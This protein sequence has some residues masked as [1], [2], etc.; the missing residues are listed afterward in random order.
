MA[1]LKCKCPECDLTFDAPA[2]ATGSV[3]CPICDT[4]APLLGGLAPRSVAE[5]GAVVGAIP[6]RTAPPVSQSSTR[7]AN[8]AAAAIMAP[9]GTA[10]A[11]HA[12]PTS[13]ALTTAPNIVPAPIALAEPEPAPANARR[14]GAMIFLGALA[15]CLLAGLVGAIF[16]V[17]AVW[18]STDSNLAGKGSKSSSTSSG[19]SYDPGN[20]GGGGKGSGDSSGSPVNHKPALPQELQDKV[21]AAVLKGRE[22][23]YTQV[24]SGSIRQL[25]SERPG[26]ALA[27]AALTLLECGVSADDPAIRNAAK[28]IRELN[29]NSNSTYGMALAILFLDRLGEAADEGLIQTLAMRLIA[30][31]LPSGMWT[32]DGRVTLTPDDEKRFYDYLKTVDYDSD[33]LAG[34]GN[35]LTNEP[36]KLPQAVQNTPI[37]IVI[38]QGWKPG[39]GIAFGGGGDN[40]NT[41][42]GLL[43]LWVAKRHGVPVQP[44]LAFVE[45]HFRK[46]QMNDGSWGYGGPRWKASMTCAGLLGIAVGRGVRADKD[47]GEDATL[48]KG[49]DFLASTIVK[50][51]G[52]PRRDGRIVA[53]DSLGDLYYLWSLERVAMVY[54]LQN[55]GGKDWYLWAAEALVPTQQPDGSWQD[56]HGAA[57]DTSFALLVLKR[58]N[59]AQDLTR[60]LKKLINV[61]DLEKPKD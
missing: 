46:T 2:T 30:G 27:L 7:S 35:K 36:A 11:I 40:S 56:A 47:A 13:A 32:Y 8:G 17:I 43:G 14:V 10:P 6:A 52:G 59:V 5:R 21:N 34:R 54:D 12:V 19:S 18:R 16:I 4:L 22:F 58:V 48:K 55:I 61:K 29:K 39:G 44:S 31:Q 51:E 45:Q 37:V 20:D 42:F 24:K 33:V 38:Q 28:E 23:L 50:R 60:N 25:H 49:M 41:Q 1:G 15:V 53:A 3:N 26:G 57:I 9:A